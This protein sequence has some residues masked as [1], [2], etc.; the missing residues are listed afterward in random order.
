[1]LNWRVSVVVDKELNKDL[2]FYKGHV[3]DVYS[4]IYMKEVYVI[5]NPHDFK[6]KINVK[7]T[8]LV[9]FKEAKESIP[10]VT[11]LKYICYAPEII[12]KLSKSTDEEIQKLVCSN[13]K[14]CGTIIFLKQ[15]EKIKI[16]LIKNQRKN[17][18]SFPK[19]HIEFGETEEQTAIRETLEE[20]GLRVKILSGFRETITY[21]LSGKIKKTVVLFAAT[22]DS[23]NV[24]IQ[25]KE[26]KSYMWVDLE[27]IESK[28]EH[29]ND[30]NAYLKAKDHFFKKTN[31]ES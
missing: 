25:R 22:T 16:L 29:Y 8:A 1:V 13:E 2:N 15:Q 7:I 27:N 4:P 9:S 30:I 3:N 19:G 20:T 21:W 5:L 23:D 24:K 26:I 12:Q 14:S 10:I 11:P 6:K 18:W 28:L 17:N 31:N